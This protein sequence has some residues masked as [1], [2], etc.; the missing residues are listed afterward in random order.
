[1]SKNSC[2]GSGRAVTI[3]VTALQKIVTGWLHDSVRVA[4]PLTYN[5]H[6]LVSIASMNKLLAPDDSPKNSH[7]PRLMLYAVVVA[8]ATLAAYSNF[9]PNELQFDDLRTIKE[10]IYIRD[11]RNIP[12]LFA[13]A[14][15]YTA[16]AANAAYRPIAG[17]SFALDYAWAGPDTR[18]FHATQLLLHLLF[19][20][21]IWRLFTRFLRVAGCG[22]GGDFLAL[23]GAALFALHRA[24]TMTLN[25]LSARGE[26]L[27]ALGAVGTIQ[28]Y[29]ACPRLRRSGVWL[30]PMAIGA[31]AKPTALMTA[32]L[33]GLLL[34]LLPESVEQSDRAPS[35]AQ[36]AIWKPVAAP[37]V[38]AAALYL[39]LSRM[40]GAHLHYGRSTPA[41]YL[42][43][44]C[45]IWLQYLRLFF[46]P[47]G[48]SA[49]YD[50]ELITPWYD[51]R[52]FF[53]ALLSLAWCGL[54]IWWS[55]RSLRGR[56]FLAGTGWY[57]I[58]LAPSSSFMP[59][60]DV[61]V[62]YR[63]YFPMVGLIMCV[64]A[65]LLPFT[66]AARYA[67]RWPLMGAGLA[68]L[69][70][71]HALGTYQRN[72]VWKNERTLWQNVVEVNPRNG[73]AWAMLGS[74]HMR[75]GTKTAARRCAE[76]AERWAPKYYINAFTLATLDYQDGKIDAA[77]ARLKEMSELWPNVPDVRGVYGEWL[78][79]QKQYDAA[80][81]QFQIGLRLS[82]GHRL[83]RKSLLRTY[84]E[85]LRWADY[86]KLA[87]ETLRFDPNPELRGATGRRCTD[88]RT[89]IASPPASAPKAN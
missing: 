68:L 16:T 80:I 84:A 55:C 54:A 28:C 34:W 22:S 41:A 42:G 40:G 2:V 64:L 26:I 48:L 14:E 51:T 89:P 29:L 36:S 85:T 4:V 20:V 59:L 53:G 12:L 50:W 83:I 70:A 69:L 35:R 10:N 57:F 67:E 5:P 62:D 71:L 1:M 15:T 25:Y 86:C 88:N 44:Q 31:L 79:D 47:L 38:L 46:L 87:Y 7:H 13:D 81:A 63:L 17:L 45:F 27:A 11:L 19:A 24:N 76:E 77:G 43:T 37:F 66:D 61:M 8:L 82:P 3:I 33:L 78:H 75:A 23:G 56:L 9:F 52:I 74:L 65:A 60:N 39:L 30:L 73:R 21:L 58:A 32:P 72:P 6:L 49:D 18:G